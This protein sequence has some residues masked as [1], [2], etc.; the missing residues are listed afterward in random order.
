MSPKV[1]TSSEDLC[2]DPSTM[3]FEQVSQMVAKGGNH[4]Q[5]SCMSGTVEQNSIGEVFALLSGFLF[6]P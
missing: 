6:L 4:D 2:L 1:D 3:S 5:S